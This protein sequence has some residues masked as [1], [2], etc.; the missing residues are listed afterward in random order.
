MGDLIDWLVVILIFGGSF[1]G[2]AMSGL[3]WLADRIARG[4]RV[5]SVSDPPL[6]GD[7]AV[8]SRSALSAAPSAPSVSETDS[9]TASDRPMIPVPS[10]D[11]MLDIFR[12]LRARGIPRSALAGP[13]R[14]AG[15]PLDNN[16]WAAAAP[17]EDAEEPP[18]AVAIRHNGAELIAPLPPRRGSYYPDAPDLEY[19]EP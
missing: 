13:W 4:R 7:D 18:R 19:Q 10:R 11:Q 15:L 14:A 5:S 9:Q 17:P 3:F 12:V 1:F 6:A 2:I 16:V 8:M